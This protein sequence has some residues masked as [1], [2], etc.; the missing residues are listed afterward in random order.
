MTKTWL[1]AIIHRF[2]SLTLK[3]I[4]HIGNNIS[5]F[6]ASLVP[7]IWTGDFVSSTVWR[8]RIQGS[9]NEVEGVSGHFREFERVLKQ[10]QWSILGNRVSNDAEG[11]WRSRGKLKLVSVILDFHIKGILIY[12]DHK[13]VDIGTWWVLI[14]L[15]SF[16]TL[17]ELWNSL[18]FRRNQP[19]DCQNTRQWLE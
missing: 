2:L 19:K 11:V 8:D 12:P 13:V 14:C 7:K 1:F 3:T 15:D 9:L 17:F 4:A 18:Q 6:E 5:S 16:V 10:N